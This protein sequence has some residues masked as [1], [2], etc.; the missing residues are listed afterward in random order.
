MDAARER[1]RR[2][3]LAPDCGVGLSGS[4]ALRDQLRAAVLEVLGDFVGDFANAPLGKMQGR[5]PA[6][7]PRPPIGSAS[8]SI[9]SHGRSPAG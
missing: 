6:A 5:E 3:E 4:P 9:V 7:D 1:L 2:L 8:P